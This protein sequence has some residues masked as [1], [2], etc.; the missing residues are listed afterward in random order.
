MGVENNI[1]KLAYYVAKF[2]VFGISDIKLAS[3]YIIRKKCLSEYK[4]VLEELRAYYSLSKDSPLKLS[5]NALK[6]IEFNKNKTITQLR[7][8]VNKIIKEN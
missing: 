1:L 2:D 8:E 7:K 3:D 6:A 5:E 4:G